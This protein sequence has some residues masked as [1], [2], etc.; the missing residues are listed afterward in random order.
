MESLFSKAPCQFQDQM[1]TV[2][3]YA[4]KHSMPMVLASW[5]QREE[6][7]EAEFVQCVLLASGFV[8]VSAVM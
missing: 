8:K 2:N 7:M 3:M 4:M 6:E 1:N 5:K